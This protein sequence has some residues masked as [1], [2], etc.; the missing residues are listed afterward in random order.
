ME[1]GTFKKY[2]STCRVSGASETSH[3]CQKNK[4]EMLWKLD[5]LAGEAI[6]VF[7]KTKIE[8]LWKLDSFASEASHVC[9]KKLEYFEN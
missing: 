2:P 6:H 4:I 7:R 8:I 5:S 1:L 3:V 9:Q